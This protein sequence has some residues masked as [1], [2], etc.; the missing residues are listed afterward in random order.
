[1]PLLWQYY[2]IAR[3]VSLWR[4]IFLFALEIWPFWSHRLLIHIS[5]EFPSLPQLFQQA[6]TLWAP[7]S[8]SEA[9]WVSLCC[10]TF[11]FRT[12]RSSSG[13][14]PSSM[15]SSFHQTSSLWQLDLLRRVAGCF[16]LP[17]TGISQLWDVLNTA[18]STGAGRQSFSSQGQ[19]QSEVD[20]S[21]R[22]S[23]LAAAD[24]PWILQIS[25]S[26]PPKIRPWF[27]S[28][29][30]DAGL[31]LSQPTGSKSHNLHS[32][33]KDFQASLT[34]TEAWRAHRQ[35]IQGEER[36]WAGCG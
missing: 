26:Q 19:Y 4:L 3:S 23:L 27:S 18:T 32:A 29:N 12:A 30:P 22:P 36:C 31:R 21:L 16:S 7:G 5:G 13:S 10:A 35:L 9:T 11:L 28:G 24:L 34:C 15:F 20:K 14:F 2:Y 33:P 6:I 8:V 25:S 17:H 1:M